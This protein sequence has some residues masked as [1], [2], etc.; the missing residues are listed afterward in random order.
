MFKI[1]QALDKPASSDVIGQIYYRAILLK[2]NLN[3]KLFLDLMIY[4]GSNFGIH[5]IRY[6]SENVDVIVNIIVLS[7]F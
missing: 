4:L 6:K 1:Q 2:G 3:L 5:S 7:F